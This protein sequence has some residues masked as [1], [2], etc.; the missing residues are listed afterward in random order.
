MAYLFCEEDLCIPPKLQRAG[1]EMMEKESGQK[2]NVTSIKA[3]HCPNVT[4]TQDVVNWIVDV[5]EK[6]KI[7]RVVA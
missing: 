1:I 3:D 6:A 7:N 4:A 5:A 2:V